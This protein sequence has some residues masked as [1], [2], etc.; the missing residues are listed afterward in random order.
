MA[1]GE[2]EIDQSESRYGRE[3]DILIEADRRKPEYL[4]SEGGEGEPITEL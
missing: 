4:V 3:Y 2:V 1:E